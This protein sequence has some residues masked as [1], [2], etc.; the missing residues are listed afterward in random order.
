MTRST[1]RMRCAS[2]IATTALLS[3]EVAAGTC[4]FKPVF[5]QAD[6]KGTQR[7]Q[8]WQ[9]DPIPA[10]GNSRP[11]LLITS[12]KV[13]TDGTKISYHQDDVTGRRCAADPAAEPCAIN[14]VR[15]AFRNP[16]RP[17]SDF[18]AIRD[19]GYPLPQT[20]QLLDPGIIEKDKTTGKPCIT[21][22]GY[23]VSMTA[24]VAIPGGFNREG[25]CDQSKWIDAL[26]TP[27]FVIPRESRF[28][29]LGVAKRST[30][31]AFSNSATRHV[32]PG[33]VGDIGP[34]N[35]VGEA[36][37]AM[38]RI[39]NGLPETDNPKHRRDAIER[40]QAGRTAILI[41]PGATTKLER[42]ISS[43]RVSD[44]GHEILSKFGGEEKL[45]HCIRSEITAEF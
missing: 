16:K 34:K 18:A 14:N 6:E 3:A 45:Y 42:P 27:A 8:V 37:V 22:D 36:N 10:L 19:A 28:L 39:L 25:D 43:Q 1:A 15:N 33:I 12:L 35:E 4:G 5:Q 11:L 38:N 20:W 31:I 17:E 26:T 29:S 32:V 23:L 21:A 24:D 2:Y 44:N 40:F 9:G 7:V 13:N 30:V 41:F